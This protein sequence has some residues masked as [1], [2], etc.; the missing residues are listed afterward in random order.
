ME[1]NQNIHQ[2]ISS[3][4]P[5]DPRKVIYFSSKQFKSNWVEL[6]K[7]LTQV[8]GECLFKTWGYKSFEEYCQ[9]ELRLKKSTAMK[10]TNAYFFLQEYEPEVFKSE[11]VP[12]L[13]SVA[14]LQKAKNNE[15]ITSESYDEFKELVFDKGQAPSTVSR[16]Y[17]DMAKVL[18]G[19]NPTVEKALT[20]VSRLR[21]NIRAITTFPEKFES[22]LEELQ[23]YLSSMGT[24][25]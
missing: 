3:L 21:Q 20:N 24:N 4:D 6:G 13:E 12:A 8:A 10:L 17:N 9:V 7:H 25:S 18:D 19:V 5:G 2:T 16:K 1:P 23:D 11:K 22:Q 14:V 15:N